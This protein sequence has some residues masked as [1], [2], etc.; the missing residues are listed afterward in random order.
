MFLTS[1]LKAQVQCINVVSN[2]ENMTFREFS[3]APWANEVK[4][5]VKSKSGFIKGLP[6]P[7]VKVQHEMYY[8]IDEPVKVKH[9]EWK[10]LI[11]GLGDHSGRLNDLTEK[12]LKDGYRV[13]RVD[14]IGHGR[15]LWRSLK[16]NANV[17]ETVDIRENGLSIVEILNFLNVKEVEI[18][19]HSLGGAVAL[20][21]GAYSK[22]ILN[23]ELEIK[24]NRIRL[25][26]FYAQDLGDWL[27]AQT[28]TGLT[29]SENVAKGVQ[30]FTPKVVSE[31]ISNN[32]DKNSFLINQIFSTADAMFRFLGFSDIKNSIAD[33]N[34]N[35][36]LYKN[37]EPYF[38]ELAKANGLDENDP[39]FKEE[40]DQLIRSAISVT[41]GA[42]NFNLF[43]PAQDLP[44][45]D[46][47][48]QIIAASQ[49]ELVPLSM[50]KQA[51]LYLLEIGYN[52]SPLIEIKK[53]GHLLTRTHPDQ[54]YKALKKR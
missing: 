53:A 16:N 25:I 35:V 33:P 13:I 15:T 45:K 14:L 40:I 7:L 17:D 27:A 54:V 3:D 23:K 32:I 44:R 36:I 28:V 4:Y 20:L 10:L 5:S 12:Y 18:I 11:H 29:V 50:M 8:R 38:V 1:N 39:K 6:R 42:R 22:N 52:V 41:R 21:T 30:F 48:V 24:I 9:K 31:N 34:L 47:P 46:I 37:F 2:D 43:H 26:A 51:R 49:D 19:G